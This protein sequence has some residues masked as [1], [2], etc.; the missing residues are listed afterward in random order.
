MI[1]TEF[2]TRDKVSA[3]VRVI[4]AMVGDRLGKLIQ[5]DGT[6]TDIPAVYSTHQKKIPTAQYPCIQVTAL[7]YDDNSGYKL[8]QGLVTVEDPNTLEEVTVPYT[9]SHITY[10]LSLV[11][12][13]DDSQAI[14]EK[15]RGSMNFDRWKD[16]VH[17][18]MES[19]FQVLTSIN[20]TPTLVETDWVDGHSMIMRFTTISTHIDLQGTWWNVISFSGDVY[21]NQEDTNPIE[22]P[23]RETDTSI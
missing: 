10:A 7:P 12:T 6:V 20:Y 11:C 18:E 15:I 3:L 1:I 23:E 16:L 5:P 9:S 22:V 8:D 19:G 2:N 14:L 21:R 17:T 4:T 13:G